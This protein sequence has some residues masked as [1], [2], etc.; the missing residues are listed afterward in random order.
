M[1]LTHEIAQNVIKVIHVSD[2]L[3]I[4]KRNVLKKIS[5]QYRICFS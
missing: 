3:T 1:V 4:R 5:K 2:G